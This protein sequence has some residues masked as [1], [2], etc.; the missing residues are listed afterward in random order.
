LFGRF[1][2]FGR[3][4]RTFRRGLR[5]NVDDYFSRLLRRLW[6]QIDDRERGDVKSEHDGD[7]EGAEPWR[8]DRRR[9]ED[10]PVQSGRGHGAGAFGGAEFGALGGAGVGETAPRGPDTMAMRVTPFA[11]SSSITDTTSP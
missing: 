5:L 8:A 6:G 3:R 2:L 9:L 4:R 1:R 7:D 10:A 11:A